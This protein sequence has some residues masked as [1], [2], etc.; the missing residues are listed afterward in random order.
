MTR[1]AFALLLG[2][3]TAFAASQAEGM[4]VVQDKKKDKKKDAVEA[5]AGDIKDD[6]SRVLP[7][8]DPGSHTRAISAMGFTPDKTKLVTVGK[9]F[10]VQVWNAG[11]GERLDIL[12]LPGYGREKGYDPNHWD[13]AAVSPDGTMVA[14][15]GHAKWL[16]D[17]AKSEPVRLVVLHLP[18]RKI[19]R[20]VIAG[21]AAPIT[22]LA[23]SRSNRSLAVSFAGLGKT[24]SRLVVLGNL[25]MRMG[26]DRPEMLVETNTILR[27]SQLAPIRSLAFSHDES[28][29]IGSYGDRV[30]LWEVPTGLS[31]TPRLVKE[32][33]VEGSTHSL[34]WSPD[35]KQF[36]RAADGD[37]KSDLRAIELWNA[38]GTK[39]KVWKASDLNAVFAFRAGKL[40]TVKFLNAQTLYIVGNGLAE[41]KD[42]G[43]SLAGTIDL[44]T[45]KDTRLA[46]DSDGMLKDP[47]G[48]ASAD[49]SLVAVTVNGNNE[50][51]LG[52]SVAGGLR[53]RCGAQ[54]QM[55]FHVG[56][57]KDPAKPGFAWSDENHVGR[58]ATTSD[59]LRFG[60][61][62][63]RVEP[64]GAIKGEDYLPTMR[65]LGDWT[66]E[67][68]GNKGGSKEEGTGLARL[69]QGGK[70]VSGFPGPKGVGHT[71][72]PNGDKPPLVVSTNHI[73]NQGDVSILY[74]AD[75]TRIVRLLPQVIRINDMATSPDGRFL[76]CTTGTPRLVVYRTDGSPYPFL[77]FAQLNGEWVCW[78]PE[79]YY[80]ASPGGEKMF[81]WAVNNGPNTL[82]SF[83]PAEKFA[84]QFRRP[85]VIKLAI[86]KGSV[87]EALAILNAVPAK[88]E[89]ILPPAAK[90]E[91]V[92]QDG[93]AV[94]VKAA[95]TSGAKDKP[96]LAMRVLL[97]GRPLPGGNGVWAPIPGM[98][99]ESDFTLTVPPGLH[100]LMVLARSDDGTAVSEPLL[101]RGPKSPGSQPTLHRV[102]V[103][104]N[105]YDLPGLRLPTAAKDARDV[106]GALEAHCVG[107][108]NRFGTAKGELILDKDATAP[109]V[110]AAI[111]NA[112]KLAR[113]G[114]LLVIFFSGHGAK[115][116]DG[117]YLLTREADPSQALKGKSISGSDLCDALADVECS[118]LFVLDACQSG[119]IRSAIDDLTRMLTNE[120]V[121]VTVMSAAMAHETASG[122]SENGFFT[123][124]LLKGLKAGEGVPYDPYER[125]IYVHHLYA[126]TYSEV[127]KA[128]NGRQNP[129]LL[130][131]WTVPPMA[132]REVPLK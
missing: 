85:D 67:F 46:A 109:R 41:K 78:T 95:A 79:G 28:R 72:V 77:S 128:T 34:D 25:P 5:P 106:Y 14:I 81:G 129:F 104:I 89:E 45:G 86:E 3:L 20:V 91:L 27:T 122:T 125:Q 74:N 52:K 103:G 49:G 119:G 88:V 13:V 59:M 48:C 15:G 40:F 70:F 82:V 2:S 17:N 108:N 84:K 73:E 11:T 102:C 42:G 7:V 75:G 76:I 118:V 105:D 96:V 107:P 51:L 101:V 130:N 113:G 26:R 132:I 87:K 10:T 127:R 24:D 123:Q 80:A 117:Y 4:A 61:D 83:Y 68:P 116:N 31:P 126:V 124:G 8:F 19:K 131:P 111:A 30:G 112:K 6:L 12:R 60:F 65:K 9:D 115:S 120:K 90:I 62:L 44:V 43:A 53:V 63:S 98:A 16:Y 114:D 32:I 36:A 99:V 110:L 38:D 29:L 100:E 37:L 93:A 54:N 92:A 57:A 121:G 35:S 50:V 39:A 47:V 55:P 1:Y 21:N 33:A 58:E 69:K 66:L 23:F 97:D 64:V 94:K 18:T 71:L 22:A 56:W